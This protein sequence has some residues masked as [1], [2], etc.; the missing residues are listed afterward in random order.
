MLFETGSPHYVK[1]VDNIHQI[2]VQY[3]K[4]KTNIEE[5]AISKNIMKV[6]VC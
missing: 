5:S 6:C 1:V 2:N 3:V 4:N